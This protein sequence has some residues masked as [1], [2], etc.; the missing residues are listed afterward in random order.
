MEPLKPDI[1]KQILANR[2]QAAPADIEEYERL[3][4]QRFSVDPHVG[5][6]SISAVSVVPQ[7]TA[8]AASSVPDAV[9]RE[10][11]LAELHQKLF[12]EGKRT[13]KNKPRK[14]DK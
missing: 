12:G 10:A 7:R 2:P 4:S 9:K 11:R 13:K 14:K 5:P 6:A 3:L 8:M 1:K